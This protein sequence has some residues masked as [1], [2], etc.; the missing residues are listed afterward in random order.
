MGL[1]SD[2]EKPQV[3]QLLKLYAELIHIDSQL[4]QLELSPDLKLSLHEQEVEL[5]D[6]AIDRFGFS[7]DKMIA[8]IKQSNNKKTFF[9]RVYSCCNIFW[10]Y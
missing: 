5:L 2:V 1:S 3:K 9:G 10:I 6:N 8:A 7:T 4:D